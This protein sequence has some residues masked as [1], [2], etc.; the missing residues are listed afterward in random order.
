[1]SVYLMIGKCL[2]GKNLALIGE[3]PTGKSRSA[4]VRLAKVRL[5]KLCESHDVN[6]AL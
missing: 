3:C 5:A 4:N 2:M 6:K 1:M